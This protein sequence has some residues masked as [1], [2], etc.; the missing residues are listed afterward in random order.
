MR[1][2]D[3]LPKEVE[4]TLTSETL[5]TCPN[6]RMADIINS[7]GTAGILPK[8]ATPRISSLSW[9]LSIERPIKHCK[10]QQKTI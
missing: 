5:K 6:R 4:E 7:V 8:V 1:L 9:L 10:M 2:W 3:I